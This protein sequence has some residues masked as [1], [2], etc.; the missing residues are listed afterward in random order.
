[1]LTRDMQHYAESR[2][3]ARAY[4]CYLFSKNLPNN[5]PSISE[6]SVTDRLRKIMGDLQDCE[7]EGR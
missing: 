6:K 4:F 3:Q 2:T 5:L 1:M 7:E